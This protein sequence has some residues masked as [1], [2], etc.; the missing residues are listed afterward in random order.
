M[1]LW[2]PNGKVMMV[3]LG[4]TKNKGV[5]TD[6]SFK[7]FTDHTTFGKGG[8]ALEWLVLTHGDRDH[9]NMVEEFLKKFTVNVRNVMHGGLESDYGGLIDTLRKRKNPDSSTATI[10][11]DVARGFFDLAPK[12]SLG[13]AITV[14]ATGVETSKGDKGYVKNTRSTVLRITYAG[15]GLVLTGD[16]TRDTE[17]Q[18]VGSILLR[19]GDPQAELGANVLKI[20][21]H[22]SRRT[23]SHA[24]WLASINPNYTFISSDRS[25][26]LDDDQKPTGHRLPQ[27]LTISMVSKFCRR[28]R[29]DCVN[30]PYVMSY[31]KS[32]YEQYNAH[33][34]FKGGTVPDPGTGDVSLAW[35]ERWG[36]EG[37]FSTLA[38]MG[39]SKDPTDEGAAD[40][41]VQYRVTLNDDGTLDILATE[42]FSTFGLVA[43]LAKQ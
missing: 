19:G 15:L 41:G 34:D 35:V 30:H 2:L 14:L 26:S 22:G 42:D 25:G 40:Q 6:A 36:T 23:S 38:K 32:D 4:S 31:Q 1:V 7:Y 17:L 37:I 28:L 29:T 3:D 21:H 39:V 8:Q 18:I 33:P 24:G 10:T 16:A 11:S 27:A 9:Y 43:K 20:G 12:D 13:A 5:V